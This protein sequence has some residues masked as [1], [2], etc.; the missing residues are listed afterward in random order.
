VTA[1]RAVQLDAPLVRIMAAYGVGDTLNARAT[2]YC[3][4]MK[5]REI[6]A[7]NLSKAGWS[8]GCVAAIDREGRTIF[9]E[10]LDQ[11]N[12]GLMFWIKFDHVIRLMCSAA[13]M[14]AKWVWRVRAIVVTKNQSGDRKTISR[15]LSETES[16][17]AQI[18]NA[19]Q[20]AS[21]RKSH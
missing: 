3:T 17:L 14:I 1:R 2:N 9:Q 12:V 6:I 20:W 13:N 15:P 8:W 18:R 10:W 16:N 21:E 4:C 19:N 7:D 5:Y 11:K